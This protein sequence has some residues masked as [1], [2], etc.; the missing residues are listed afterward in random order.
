VQNPTPILVNQYGGADLPQAFV[1]I[2][3]FSNA[4]FVLNH[5]PTSIT[6]TNELI[7]LEIQDIG[8]LTAK[9]LIAEPTVL[10]HAGD[11]LLCQREVILSNAPLVPEGRSIAT[12][13]P[14]VMENS[15]PIW[16]VQFDSGVAVCEKGYFIIHFLS[17]GDLTTVVDR[18]TAELPENSI[19]LRTSFSLREV[20]PL[21]QEEGIFAIQSPSLDDLFVGTQYFV[22]QAKQIIHELAPDAEF[23]PPDTEVDIFV[24]EPVAD[25]ET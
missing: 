10:P 5:F 16:I 12:I 21:P 24:E 18:L 13:A 6:R 9:F 7:E 22:D 3:S 20:V 19:V 17:M 4:V 11:R 8:K 23:F 14:G 15:N 25:P 1:Q 2:A